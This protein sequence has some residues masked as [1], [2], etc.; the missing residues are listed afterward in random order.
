MSP[1]ALWGSLIRSLRRSC[2]GCH[3]KSVVGDGEV[4]FTGLVSAHHVKHD[5]ARAA[6]AL[7]NLQ[8]L[9]RPFERMVIYAGDQVARAQYKA[10]RL[11]MVHLH[12]APARKP[13]LTALSLNFEQIQEMRNPSC[14]GDHQITS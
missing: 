4:N 2:D 1:S 9:L 3:G 13:T 12:D 11:S 6:Q 5:F 7:P 14:Q 10:I 8:E